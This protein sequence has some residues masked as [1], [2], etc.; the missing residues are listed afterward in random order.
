MA[1]E[2][3]GAVGMP[4]VNHAP[5]AHITFEGRIGDGVATGARALVQCFVAERCGGFEQQPRS[6]DVVTVGKA[7]VVFQLPSVVEKESQMAVLRLQDSREEDFQ[8]VAGLLAQPPPS[9][10]MRSRLV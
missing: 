5:V 3:P 6:L 8:Q 10:Q 4:F 7:A 1:F 9:S 2:I